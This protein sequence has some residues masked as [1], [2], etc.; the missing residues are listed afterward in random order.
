V[1]PEAAPEAT[2]S[3]TLYPM[4][5]RV[6]GGMLALVRFLMTLQNKRM[7]VARFTVGRDRDALRITLLLECP[8]EQARRYTELLSGLEDVEEIQPNVDTMEV[9]LLKTRGDGWRESAAGVKIHEEGAT[10]VASGEPGVLE[11]WLTGLGDDVE[12]LV[13]LGPVARPGN[14]GH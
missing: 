4:E 12:D 11:A 2:S 9:A 14:G 7:P 10:V 5:A 8:P 1:T 3:T 6:S 13:R